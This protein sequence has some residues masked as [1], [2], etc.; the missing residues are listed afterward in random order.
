[1]EYERTKDGQIQADFS[2]RI[3][4]VLIQYGQLSQQL[5][6]DQRYEITLCVCLLQALLTNC[7]ETIK[8]NRFLNM[9]A[10]KDLSSMKL[11]KDPVRLGL[12]IECIEYYSGDLSSL[13]YSGLLGC[14]R[15]AL[16]HPNNQDDSNPDAPVTGYTTSKAESG[17]LEEIIFIWSPW[18]CERKR[19]LRDIFRPYSGA[20]NRRKLERECKNLKLKLGITDLEI[21]EAPGGYLEVLRDGRAFRPEMRVRLT[22]TQL[23]TLTLELSQHLAEPLE[24]VTYA[25]QI[26]GLQRVST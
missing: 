14:L 13:T 11:D 9:K 8:K 22:S 1:M 18:V 24:K 3:G 19:Q 16:S 20:E 2:R 23:R 5:P 4:Q 26:D 6:Q 15:D 21:R 25:N 17:N 12:S 10:L 7:S